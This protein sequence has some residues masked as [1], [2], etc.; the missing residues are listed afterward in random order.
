MKP[1]FF[2]T[3]AELRA[4]FEANHDK[5]AELYIGYY[6]K[7]SGKGGMVYKEALDEAICYGWIDGRVNS[8][9]ET[10]YQQRWTPRKPNSY[11]SQVNIRKANALIEAGRMA[12]PGL[13]AFER[14]DASGKKRYSFEN[15]SGELP[16]PWLKRFKANKAAWTWFQE[17]RP[18][19][20]RAAL[21]WTMSAKQEATRERRLA[22]LIECSAEGKYIPPFRVSTNTDKDGRPLQAAKKA[23]TKKASKAKTAA[24]RS[25]PR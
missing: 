20:R 9:D 3:P 2:R 5:V 17:I 15:E 19:Y 6:K 11:W 10:C 24:K 1:K 23:A 13:A 12:P 18:S 4:W 16:L 21:Y 22:T 25:R 7:G 14:R 8:I